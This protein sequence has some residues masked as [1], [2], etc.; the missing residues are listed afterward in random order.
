[1]VGG[2][3]DDGPGGWFDGNKGGG[4]SKCAKC[5]SQ[6]RQATQNKYNNEMALQYCNVPST[7]PFMHTQQTIY[8]QDK[9]TD[10][11]R[12]KCGLFLPKKQLM[13]ATILESKHSALSTSVHSPSSLSE[14]MQS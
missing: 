7:S 11:D 9:Q 3:V 6:Y 13:L 4:V 5:N 1:M 12:E 8:T 10:R 2:K 14:P